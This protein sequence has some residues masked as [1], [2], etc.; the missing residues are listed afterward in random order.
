MSVRKESNL[1]EPPESP[2]YPVVEE[3]HGDKVYDP[4]RWLED[5][6][7]PEVLEW[8]KKQN[9]RTDEVFGQFLQHAK[10]QSRYEDILSAEVVDSPSFAGGN[11]FFTRRCRGEEQPALCVLEDG[12]ERIVLDPNIESDAGLVTL[13]WWH[14]SPDGR[15]VAYGYSFGGD[16]WST[17]RILDMESGDT[18]PEEIDRT[19]RTNLA[20]EKDSAGF[21]YTRLPEPGTVPDGE[22][23]YHRHIFYHRLG[24]DPDTDPKIFG[25]GRCMLDMYG[26]SLSNDGEYLMVTS[27]RAVTDTE[28]YVRPTGC[29]NRPFKQI[30]SGKDA[31]FQGSIIDGTAYLLTNYRANNW[32]MISVDLENP[33]E[34]CWREVVPERSDV[35]WQDLR[36][37]DDE[38]LA[39]GWSDVVS[40]MFIYDKDGRE[41]EDITL[42]LEGSAGSVAFDST[43][44]R[45][46]FTLQS[47]FTPPGIYFLDKDTRRVEPFRLSEQVVDPDDFRVE[48]IFYR[49][50]VDGIAVP[51]F[52]MHRKDLEIEGPLPTVLL[53]YGGYNVV[54][55][56][57]YKAAIIPWLQSGG[58]YAK[59]NIRGGGEYGE[60][61]HRQGI[62]H[63]RQDAYYDFFAAMEYL[64]E[65]GYTDP[66]HLGITGRSNGGLL[67][68]AVITQRPDLFRA[69]ACGVPLTDMLRYHRFLVAS[70]WIPEYGNPDTDPEAFRW[71]SGYSPYHHVEDGVAYPGMY[72]YA[73]FGDS[74]VH[75]MHACKM[76]AR[77]QTA[78]SSEEPILLHVD[79]D[80]GH[81][82]G[83]PISQLC[84][85]E[86]CIWSF[87]FWRLGLD[88]V[89]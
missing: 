18:L 78:T 30:I 66:E 17:L 83:K 10:L 36:F 70:S 21:Y 87:F 42:P 41:I 28:V 71:L 31:R 20:W 12:Q 22:E 88:L 34:E 51:M 3:M 48:K 37:V 43:D 13:D 72:L 38:I 68:A 67:T 55:S 62:R 63:K 49:S 44:N 33:E 61:W 58:I 80:A 8:I 27:S 82:I 75:P 6:G 65:K 74:R 24:T 86:A 2:R 29:L 47:F 46:Y 32:R 59:A 76:A 26:V 1:P 60:S 53:G 57:S 40:R 89:D 15:L 54:N 39:V 45:V 69:A 79:S 81:G 56:P 4:Y 64:V 73:A 52:I 11:L 77:L 7:D 19:P 14:P 84:Y 50:P 25:E 9:V 16:E 23:H 85:Q 5:A 35:V